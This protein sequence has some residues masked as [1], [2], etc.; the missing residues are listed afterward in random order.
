MTIA[1]LCSKRQQLMPRETKPEDGT[2]AATPRT[3]VVF[4]GAI[5]D[6]METD[7]RQKLTDA[8]QI[9]EFF[10]R[11]FAEALSGFFDCQVA[12]KANPASQTSAGL[13]STQSRY[14]IKRPKPDVTSVS[15]D[16]SY[17]W[18]KWAFHTL[19]TPTAGITLLCFDLSPSS[20]AALQKALMT[21]DGHDISQDPFSIHVFLIEQLLL[22]YDD[23]VW[24]WNSFVRSL[25][26]ASNPA[27]H[28][29]EPPT[30]SHINTREQNRPSWDA[31]RPDYIAMHNLARHIIHS[32]ETLATGMETMKVLAQEYDILR[33]EQPTV[34]ATPRELAAENQRRLRSYLGMMKALHLRAEAAKA[35]VQNEINLAFNIVAQRD[36]RASVLI[37][38]E[39][40]ADNLAMKTISILGLVFLP[41]T[42]ISALFS[43]AFF[44]FAPAE[45]GVVSSKFWIYWAV[46]VPVTLVT[47]ATWYRWQVAL[48]RGKGG[49]ADSTC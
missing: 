4:L 22:A 15:D 42:F 13:L 18:L 12:R 23:A 43:T 11:K 47:F 16:D 41:G 28:R 32:A 10:W 49:N 17:E 33:A 1:E 38:E 21:T 35:R 9:P 39:A 46:T 45:N 7:A 2:H 25:E 19:W 27:A 29:R 40:R 6:L 8:Y 14:E 37:G 24:A 26:K 3:T 5:K 30:H 48:G 44:N 36:S 31:P 34:Q 20:R